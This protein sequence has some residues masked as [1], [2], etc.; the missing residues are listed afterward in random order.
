M[1]RL[2]IGITC[3]PTF[4]GS[5]VIATELGLALADL[6]HEVHFISSRIPVRLQTNSM[7]D[8]SFHEVNTFTY[9]LFQDRPYTLTLAAKMAE[10]AETYGLDLLHVHYAIPHAISAHLAQEMLEGR[11]RVV[12]TLHGTDITLVGQ[13][14]SLH[15]I[16]RFAI[17]RSDVVT[18]VSQWLK[19]ETDK[20]FRPQRQV[21]VVRNFVDSRLFTPQAASPWPGRH[22]CA[23]NVPT[24]IH[25]SNFRPV[26]RAQ[27]AVDIFAKVL[28]QHDCRLLMVGDGPDLGTALQR[29][30]QLGIADKVSFLGNRE[31][32][33]N[34][35]AS[36]DIVLVPSS[37]ESFGL[38]ALEAMACGCAVVSSNIGGLPEVFE[39]GVQ[40][41][42]CELGDTEAM[43]ARV[44]ELLADPQR[45]AAMQQAARQLAVEKFD[46]SAVIPEYIRVYGM[47]L[48]RDLLAEGMHL[49]PPENG[50]GRAGQGE[51]LQLCAGQPLRSP[52]E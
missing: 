45:L 5:G 23:G 7:A 52:G 18:A 10:V 31:D 48:G 25:V 44:S 35:L 13:D 16:T 36:S 14:P 4:G 32:V 46:I 12:T 29:A 33:A 40:G 42:Q 34:L 9:A 24:L 49:P 15:K 21:E 39:D 22:L 41:F 20:E 28:T 38:S 30:R 37:S 1:E 27:D 17:N 43:A 50:N 2:K 26:K 6:G 8:V 19:D 11:V 3:Y 51:A 47:A